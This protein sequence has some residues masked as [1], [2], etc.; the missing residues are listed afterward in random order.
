MWISL[1]LQM[2][3]YHRQ[4]FF[5]FFNPRR[6][7]CIPKVK[8]LHHNHNFQSDYEQ[9]VLPHVSHT[10]IYKS[11]NR[12]SLEMV[13]SLNHLVI[14]FS[15]AWLVILSKINMNSFFLVMGKTINSTEMNFLSLNPVL[16]SIFYLFIPPKKGY[17]YFLAN[18]K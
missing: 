10:S 13:F 2:V 9:D 8:A 12:F 5:F 18:K 6:E 1:L 11:K 16:T 3:N 7:C 15:S 4:S 14:F 17:L